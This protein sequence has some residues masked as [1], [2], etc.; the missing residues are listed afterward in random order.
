MVIVGRF[1]YKADNC[2]TKIYNRLEVT[3]EKQL[4][5]MTVETNLALQVLVKGETVLDTPQTFNPSNRSQ[6]NLTVE[7]PEAL[8]EFEI[9]LSDKE[10]LG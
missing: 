5:T 1:R 8:V 7:D 4:I 3:K 10:P 9:R 2:V 6:F